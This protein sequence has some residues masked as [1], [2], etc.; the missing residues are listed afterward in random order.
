VQDTLSEEDLVNEDNAQILQ[1]LEDGVAIRK[2][3]E[4]DA[5]KLID[6]ACK[7]IALNARMNLLNIEVKPENM[8]AII[9]MQ[10]IGKLYDNVLGNIKKS[11]IDMG[12]M[13]FNEAKSRGLIENP[14]SE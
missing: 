13:A 7:K 3:Q 6:K 9:E 2:L 12:E 1:M 14:E 4:N 11:F 5:F 10:I 8:T